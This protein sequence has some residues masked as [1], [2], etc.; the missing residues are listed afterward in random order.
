M[1]F[2]L[3]ILFRD[4]PDCLNKLKPFSQEIVFNLNT[5][6]K[7][8]YSGNM[9]KR[10][11]IQLPK[12]ISAISYYSENTAHYDNYTIFKGT[13]NQITG[14]LGGYLIFNKIVTGDKDFAKIII[15]GILGI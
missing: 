1:Y 11:D 7:N 8:E 13:Y 2:Y 14:W 12:N 10:I 6:E 15:N 3:G 9:Y 5:F 4:Y